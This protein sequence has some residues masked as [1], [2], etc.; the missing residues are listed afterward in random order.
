[1]SP[2]TK[3][4]KARHVL[5][6]SALLA[7]LND[8]PGASA[9]EPI[10]PRSTISAVNLAEVFTKLMSVDVAIDNVGI[11]LEA[12]GLRVIAFTSR[13]AQI[14]AAYYPRTKHLG[15]S[16]GDRAC[17]ALAL[18]LKAPAWTADAAWTKVN[19]PVEVKLIR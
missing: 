8:E 7:F 14:A 16:L 13:D 12:M 10:L 9:V 5:D 18:R 2:R 4:P 11:R 3:R 15:L 6:A 1:V 19:S 17:F